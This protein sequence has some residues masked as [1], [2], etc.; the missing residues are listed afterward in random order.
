MSCEVSYIKEKAMSEEEIALRITVECNSCH[1]Q[2]FDWQEKT[3]FR[4]LLTGKH[5][6]VCPACG[7]DTWSLIVRKSVPANYS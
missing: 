4:Y 2:V 3:V 5:P 1:Y 7:N 6:G